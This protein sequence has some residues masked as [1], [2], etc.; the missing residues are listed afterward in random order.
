MGKTELGFRDRVSSAPSSPITPRRRISFNLED[1]SPSPIDHLF[2]TPREEKTVDI[3]ERLKELIEALHS[4]L[5]E[6]SDHASWFLDQIN[7][8]IKVMEEFEEIPKEFFSPLVQLE[9]IR[10]KVSADS[11]TVGSTENLSLEQP[12]LEL[13]AIDGERSWGEQKISRDEKP[14]DAKSEQSSTANPMELSASANEESNVPHSPHEHEISEQ[15]E[16]LLRNTDDGGSTLGLDLD[17]STAPHYGLHHSMGCAFA[18]LGAIISALLK[19]LKEKEH[20]LLEMKKEKKHPLIVSFKTLEDTISDMSL[21]YNFIGGQK[22][23]LITS[24][25][26]IKKL[27]ETEINLESLNPKKITECKS[28]IDACNQ[29]ISSNS[30]DYAANDEKLKASIKELKN[31]V[32]PL[33]RKIVKLAQFL[34]VVIGMLI[35]FGVSFLTVPL[36]VVIATGVGVSGLGLFAVNRCSKQPIVKG[37]EKLSSS[38]SEAVKMKNLDLARM[39][40]LIHSRP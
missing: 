25:T 11:G 3:S 37:M 40:A 17:N 8:L 20:L 9:N 35:G 28:V 34:S 16:R 18:V 19:K 4:D 21:G 33:V 36:S 24:V 12:S 5:L 22:T 2:S 38:V 27:I 1:G 23:Q 14:K 13:S 15:S 29:L 10:R 39:R 6:K 7:S 26:E 31:N 30:T 32:D